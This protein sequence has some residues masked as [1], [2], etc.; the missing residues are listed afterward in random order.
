MRMAATQCSPQTTSEIQRDQPFPLNGPL[1]HN[2]SLPLPELKRKIGNDK[3]KVYSYVLRSVKIDRKNRTFRQL[4]S[5]PNFQGGV[6]TLCTCKHQMR[7][8]MPTDDWKGVWI[9]G[10]TSRTIHDGK[11]WLFYLA[12]LKAGHESHSDLWNALTDGTRN[13]KA[14]E[15]YFLG[16]LFRPRGAP[17]IGTAR[18][19]PQNYVITCR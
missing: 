18:Y 15:R 19:E 2:L 1:H 8:T 16:D 4:G 13:A 11:H 7:A 17:L 3:S 14:A 5:G 9:A 10:F 12:K 6:L